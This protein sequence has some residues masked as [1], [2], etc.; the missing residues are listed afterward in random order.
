[1]LLHNL[2]VNISVANILVDQV[3]VVSKLKGDHRDTILVLRLW[4][5]KKRGPKNSFSIIS[6]AEP[7]RALS[8]DL[9]EFTRSGISF[10]TIFPI[11]DIIII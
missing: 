2:Y 3:S 10:I 8:R 4:A 7:F 5:E 11:L 9:L 1:M 6:G